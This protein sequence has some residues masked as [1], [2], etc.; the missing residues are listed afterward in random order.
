MSL[1]DV[2]Y[3]KKEGLDH[4]HDYLKKSLIVKSYCIHRLVLVSSERCI[5]IRSAD[6]RSIPLRWE[7]SNVHFVKEEAK[8]QRSRGLPVLRPA[9]L[10]WAAG[11]WPLQACLST[12]LPLTGQ[13]ALALRKWEPPGRV[14]EGSVETLN[15]PRAEGVLGGGGGT[16]NVK[17]VTLKWGLCL[18]PGALSPLALDLHL[19]LPSACRVR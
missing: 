1:T 13:E 6:P 3:R 11:T 14:A 18:W 4:L 2:H 5:Y 17:T 12:L 19:L 9:A 16:L 15:P 7:L 8:A 10:R